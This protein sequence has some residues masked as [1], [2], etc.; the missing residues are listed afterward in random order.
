MAD[1]KEDE[2]EKDVAG[3]EAEGEAPEGAEGAEGDEAAAKKKKKKKLIIIG[4][5]AAILLLGGGGAGLFF[6]GVLSPHKE[7]ATTKKGKKKKKGGEGGEAERGTTGSSVKAAKGNANEWVPGVV[8]GHEA[9]DV[10]YYNLPEFLVN[11]NTGGKQVSYIKMKVTLEAATDADAESIDSRMPRITDS[12]NT[13]LRELRTS[14]IA[15][16][17]GLYRLR[18]E[19][20]LRVNK[21]IYPGK[22]N[23]VLFR[24]IIIQ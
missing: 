3:K 15:G 19:L 1:K 24:E 14:D 4:A 2:K 5:A 7:E 20:L 12:F 21:T 16:S 11:L 23:D 9:D 8:P 18:E 6:S 10:V 22:V 17:A 13:Y